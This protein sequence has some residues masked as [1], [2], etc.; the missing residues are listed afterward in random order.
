MTGGFTM[1]THS[2]VSMVLKFAN[3]LPLLMAALL[4]ST[5]SS[6]AQASS[7]EIDGVIRDT[8]QSV[9]PGAAVRLLNLTT[10][11]S[12]NVRTSS[13]GYFT[14]PL[15]PPG[16]YKI[17]VSKSGF[18]TQVR[19]EVLLQVQQRLA[20]DFVLSLASQTNQVTVISK[21]PVLSTNAH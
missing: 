9:I 2:L 21:A 5:H 11:A 10:G 19:P 16:R 15:L 7:G 3:L 14:V 20:V 17:T 4:L 8:S 12:R 1:R 18:A 6:F 13:L